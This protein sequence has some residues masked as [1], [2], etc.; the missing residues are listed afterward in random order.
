VELNACTSAYG[1]AKCTAHSE[2]YWN[3]IFAH[4]TGMQ[5]IRNDKFHVDLMKQPVDRPA[6]GLLNSEDLTVYRIVYI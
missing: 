2:A 3:L 6:S 5:P 4:A 1:S